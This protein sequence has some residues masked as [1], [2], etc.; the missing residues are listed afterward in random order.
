MINSAV[1]G[2]EEDEVVLPI[3]ELK[4]V[5]ICMWALRWG[6]FGELDIVHIEILVGDWVKVKEEL[7][8]SEKMC[9]FY[10]IALL[11]FKVAGKLDESVMVF[12][13]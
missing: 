9:P 3:I 12:A 5:N 7:V 4:G 6:L 2:R 10:G 1:I 11:L 13:E 8:N